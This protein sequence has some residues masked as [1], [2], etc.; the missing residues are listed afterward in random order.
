MDGIVALAPQLKTSHQ[1]TASNSAELHILTVIRQK[2]L[3]L[4]L[5][6]TKNNGQHNRHHSIQPFIVTRANAFL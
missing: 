1:R 4:V 6:V 5:S 2:H 3:I